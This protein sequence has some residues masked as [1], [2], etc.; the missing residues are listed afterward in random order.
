M[1][2][3]QPEHKVHQWQHQSPRAKSPRQDSFFMFW[4]NEQPHSRVSAMA[5]RHK[6]R[7]MSQEGEGSTTKRRGTKS[8]TSPRDRTS[9]PQIK[10]KTKNKTSLGKRQSAHYRNKAT[11]T[12][13]QLRTPSARKPQ[14]GDKNTNNKSKSNPGN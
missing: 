3:F 11:C 13:D 1:I 7:A 10:T 8:P 6:R 14:K 12:V 5:L 2:V 4:A 9:P